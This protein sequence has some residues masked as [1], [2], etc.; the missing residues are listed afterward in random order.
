MRALRRNKRPIHYALYIADSP[1]QDEYGNE[2]GESAPVYG[3]IQALDCNV[4]AAVGEEVVQA[5][6]SFSDYE[7]VIC[8]ADV[9]CP[10]AEQAVVWFGVPTGG[11]YN[12][13]VTLRADSKNGILYALREVKVSV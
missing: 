13:T 9:T 1:I 5:F 7:R 10:L 2:T 4:S 12:Y 11:P 8:V 3:D 6:G